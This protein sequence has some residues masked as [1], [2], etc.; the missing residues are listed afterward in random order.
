MASTPASA[1]TVS[2]VDLSGQALPGMSPGLNGVLAVPAGDGPWPAVVMVHEAFGLTDVMKRQVDRMAAAGFLVLMPDLFVDGGP[3]RCLRATFTAISAGHG[4]VFV[5][6][7]AAR[8]YL[9]GRGDCTGKVGVLGFCMGGGFALVAAS[10]HGFDAASSNYGRLP[11]EL[12]EA[13]SGAC[14]IVGSYGGRDNSLRGAA[15]K[16]DAALTTRDVPHDVKEYPTA[17]HSFLNDAPT[18][19]KIFRPL[20]SAILGAGPDPEA[21]ADAWKRIDAFFREHLA[22]GAA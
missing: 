8:A 6:V 10:G 16:L 13:F 15:A 12:D 1:P 18:G 2:T 20:F 9:V 22:S 14:P 3:R 5:D 19:P 17:G 7:E 11:S 4:R 21:A